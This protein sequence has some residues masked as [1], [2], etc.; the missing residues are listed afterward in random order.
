MRVLLLHPSDAQRFGAWTHQSWDLVVNLGRST[1]FR[2]EKA[3]NS[4]RVLHLDSYSEGLADA[5]LVRD[6]LRA[7]RGVLIDREGIDWWDLTS[8]DIV[9][10]AFTVVLLQRVAAEI[11]GPVEIWST[12]PDWSAKIV[13][14]L[15]RLPLHS[16][17]PSKPERLGGFATRY[18][19]VFRHFSPAQI[20][21]I[22]FDKYDAGYRWRSQFAAKQGRCSRPLVLIPSAYANVSR[23]A[24]AYAALVPEQ[25]FLLV[26]TRHSAYEFP[27]TKNIEV[28]SLA[29]YA[30]VRQQET[31]L[32][33]L[34]ER[35]TKLKSDLQ[36]CEG[37]R[38]LSAAGALDPLAR[39]FQS[40]LSVRDAWAQVLERQPVLSVLC[41]DDSNIY[42]RLPVL[43][44]NRRDIPTIDF[45][46]GALDGFYLFKDLTCDLYL[47]K[48]EMERDYLLR[49]CRLPETK[50]VIAPP[51]A[52]QRLPTNGRSSDGQNIV[53]FSE[54]YEIGGIRAEDVYRE[55]L[56]RLWSLAERYGN[57]LVIKLH[58]FES[59]SQR[60]RLVKRVLPEGAARRVHWIEGPLTP[61][62]FERAWFGI[63]IESTT[64]VDCALNG[65]CCFL[66]RWLK[67]L[68]YGYAEQYVRFGMGE[69][70]ESVEQIEKIPGRLEEFHNRLSARP[71]PR[72]NVAQFRQWLTS[73]SLETAHTRS[74][75]D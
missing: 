45:H 52:P 14:E 42:T 44:A 24:A 20:G 57:D 62:L 1:F 10:Q 11:H 21:Q 31:E 25:P 48:S 4:C 19:R 55:V 54:P 7:G 22:F 23:M 39:F 58:P 63:T 32:V 53:L 66:C 41:G 71:S 36:S 43:L 67:L 33:F 34:M 46:H 2:P 65:V 75:H 40:G 60:S 70:L 61:Q 16:F 64:A 9:Q 59:R 47:A 50:V 51:S 26:T 27:P 68:P 30:G 8:L 49:L 56:P 38:L 3:P 72:T 5:R 35:W 13:A 15:L 18:A 69:P 37:L 29:A 12:R 28:H 17:R 73:G 74:I 6:L